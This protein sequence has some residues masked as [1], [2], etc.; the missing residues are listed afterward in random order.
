MVP[1]KTAIGCDME[2]AFHKDMPKNIKVAL[3][4]YKD[5]F[6]TNIPLGLPLVPMIHEFKMELEDKTPPINRPI[7]KLNLLELKEA[8]EQIQYMLEHNYIK[9][10]ISPYEALVLFSPKKDGSVWFCI[11]Y[12]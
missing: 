5:I 6:P 8:K 1:E 9:P 10:S 4:N 3:L 7:Y 11:D 12:H 2:K